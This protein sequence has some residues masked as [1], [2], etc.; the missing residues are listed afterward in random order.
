MT[1]KICYNIYKIPCYVIV[2]NTYTFTTYITIYNYNK[3]KKD[4]ESFNVPGTL[5]LNQ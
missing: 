1:P 3:K 2:L 4:K 5:F